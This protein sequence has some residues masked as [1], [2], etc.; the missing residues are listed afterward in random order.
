[1]KEGEKMSEEDF[2]DLEDQIEEYKKKVHEHHIRM[3]GIIEGI[4]IRKLG[5]LEKS[6]IGLFEMIENDSKRRSNNFIR[7]VEIDAKLIQRVQ[8][9]EKRIEELENNILQ[10]R[11]TLD[12]LFQAR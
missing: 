9:L 5:P 3:K 11:E 4:R 6:F 10:L 2:R 8:N 1:L 7:F 12:K